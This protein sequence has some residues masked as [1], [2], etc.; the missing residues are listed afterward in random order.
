MEVQCHRQRGEDRG[1][2][3]WRTGVRLLR[4]ARGT[5]NRPSACCSVVA[6]SCTLGSGTRRGEVVAEPGMGHSP[7]TN[8]L[9]VSLKRDSIMY[10]YYGV[11]PGDAG[12]CGRLA[13]TRKLDERRG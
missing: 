6:R 10:F 7:M 4:A 9:T 3:C 2:A 11:V 8:P 1:G 5:K 13:T 12:H